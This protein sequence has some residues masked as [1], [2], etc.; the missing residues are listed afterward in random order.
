MVIYL[1][2]TQ[3]VSEL[4]LEIFLIRKKKTEQGPSALPAFYT[5]SCLL[6]GHPLLASD[7][8]SPTQVGKWKVGVATELGVQEDRSGQQRQRSRPGCPAEDNDEQ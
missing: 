4:N 5:P 6:W 3:S 8:L 1:N 7:V 2:P